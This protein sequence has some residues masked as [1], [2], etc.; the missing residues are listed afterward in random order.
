VKKQLILKCAL[1]TLALTTT[2]VSARERTN[3]LSASVPVFNLSQGDPYGATSEHWA[4]GAA[5]EDKGDFDSAIIQY[6][7][8][9]D[10]VANIPDQHLRDCA[11]QGS[12]ARSE[13]AEAGK[14]YLRTHEISSQTRQAALE[15]SRTQF[16]RV[17]E[18]M[19]SERPDLATSCP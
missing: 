17:I 15:V 13:G 3:W 16:A 5:L 18:Q 2:G 11:I 12:I 7:K 1:I 14:R 9:L 19:D 10:A 8:A 6:K 4:Q